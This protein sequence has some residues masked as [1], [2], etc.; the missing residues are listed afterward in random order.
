MYF[1]WA[2]FELLHHDDESSHTPSSVPSYLKSSPYKGICLTPLSSSSSK[3]VFLQIFLLLIGSSSMVSSTAIST[4]SSG[5]TEDIGVIIIILRRCRWYTGT[6][7]WYQLK[8]EWMDTME[9]RMLVK[10]LSNNRHYAKRYWWWSNSF[11]IQQ[12]MLSQDSQLIKIIPRN[13]RHR[14]LPRICI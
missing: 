8:N 7:S 9:W 10:W 1:S 13:P 5:V 14:R 3:M 11:Y 4:N 2:Q 6:L 12:A